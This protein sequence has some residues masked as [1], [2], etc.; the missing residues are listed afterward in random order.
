MD[1]TSFALLDIDP[2][3]TLSATQP[4]FNGLLRRHPADNA[5]VM[6]QQHSAASVRALAGCYEPRATAG[7]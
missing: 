3:A 7:R 1:S 2:A 6:L 4:F 5:A